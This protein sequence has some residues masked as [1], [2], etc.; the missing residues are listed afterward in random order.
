MSETLSLLVER[1]RERIRPVCPNMP[2]AEFEALT[3]RMADIEHK[4]LARHDDFAV[5]HAPSTGRLP[6]DQNRAGAAP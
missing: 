5:G 4:Y 1:I 3:Q 6:P 2:D